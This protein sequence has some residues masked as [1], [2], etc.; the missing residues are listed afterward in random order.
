MASDVVLEQNPI[1]TEHLACFGNNLTS[2]ACVIHFRERS[3][4]IGQLALSLKLGKAQAEELHARQIRE[5][6]GKLALNDLKASQRLAKLDAAARIAAKT[7]LCPDC[8]D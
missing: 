5:H 3:P 1:A 6:D 8:P 7:W 2:Q 4:G